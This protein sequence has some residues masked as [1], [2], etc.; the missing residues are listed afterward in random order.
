[1]GSVRNRY[2]SNSVHPPN[3]YNLNSVYHY[4]GT[5]CTRYIPKAL[6]EKILIEYKLGSTSLTRYISKSVQPKLGISPNGYNSC[7]VHPQ[8]FI[9]EYLVQYKLGTMQ[10]RYIPKSV[11][12]KHGTSSILIYILNT[13][14]LPSEAF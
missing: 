14:E 2:N 6:F 10:P 1:M 8:C 13:H 11:Q 3:R 9:W 12:I 4:M 7:S 5:T